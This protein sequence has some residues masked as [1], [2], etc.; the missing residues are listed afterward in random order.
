MNIEKSS[1]SG[2]SGEHDE[3]KTRD[4][5]G[6]L[7]SLTKNKKTAAFAGAILAGT[8]AMEQNAQA[9]ENLMSEENMKRIVGEAREAVN[10][11]TL[12]PERI[13]Q[14]GKMA[15]KI[16]DNYK[17]RIG[18]ISSKDDRIKRRRV[19]VTTKMANHEMVFLAGYMGNGNNQV[20]YPEQMR[21]YAFM[22]DY[23]PENDPELTFLKDSID[24]RLTFVRPP[25]ERV[26]TKDKDGENN[27]RNTDSRGTVT[28][29]N[30]YILP[31]DF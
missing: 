4:N 26:N 19:D 5:G 12:S 25:V 9:G 1:E 28:S 16:I 18:N 30:D 24:S 13:L 20:T 7:E 6:V 23:I 17:R 21:A 8:M 29:G 15:Q 14:A 10:W 27:K 2:H 22:A 11:K 31:S 3:K